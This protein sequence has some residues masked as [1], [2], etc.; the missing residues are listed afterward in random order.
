MSQTILD[1]TKLDRILHIKIRHNTFSSTRPS[2]DSPLLLPSF[3]FLFSSSFFF[4]IPL[5]LPL[6]H[7][8]PVRLPTSN[9]V[10][11]RSTIAQH[12]LNDETGESQLCIS[13]T[14]LS[15][16]TACTTLQ[17]SSSCL[18]TS[19]SVTHSRVCVFFLLQIRI[20]GSR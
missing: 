19:P 5:P 12:L 20:T 4:L 7:R 6:P 13:S 2:N 1:S 14:L 17:L 15:T 16:S 8:D 9:I 11:D 18:I 3:F 10:V